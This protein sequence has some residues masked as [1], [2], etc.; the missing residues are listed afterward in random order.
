ME[1]SV[2]WLTDWRIC[3]WCDNLIPGIVAAVAGV[4]S[5]AN[6]CTQ[7]HL[8]MFQLAFTWATDQMSRSFPSS[9]GSSTCTW[10]TVGGNMSDKNLEQR[11]N[12]I[13]YVHYGPLEWKEF[14]RWQH[15]CKGQRWFSPYR[16]LYIP[17]QGV[18]DS[19]MLFTKNVW[20]ERLMGKSRLFFRRID[21]TN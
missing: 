8:D 18:Y 17:R 6:T 4:L 13:T 10:Y 5:Q 2:K 19:Y 20:N 14:H 7:V 1:V 16:I 11:I 21:T 12:I 3:T 9:R 15:M